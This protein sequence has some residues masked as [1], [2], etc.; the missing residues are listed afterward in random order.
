M[1]AMKTPNLFRAGVLLALL[2]LLALC[3]PHVFPSSQTKKYVILAW[4]DLGM[5]CYSPD[6]EDMAILPPY[7]N[8]FAQVIEAGDPPKIITEGIVVEYSF[9]ENTYSAGKP[10]M[11]DKTNFWDHVKKLFNAKP[12]VN[13]GLAGKRLSGIMD[14]AGDH[15]VA[16]GI[17]LTEYRDADADARQPRQDWNRYPYQLAL[18]VVK[19]KTS[20]AEL[21]RATAVAPVSS[22]LNCAKCHS[23]DGIASKE[24]KIRVTGK[25]ATNILTLHDKFNRKKY[26]VALMDSRPVLCAGCHAS[27][28]LGAK[29][30]RGIP[31]F[32]HAIHE[33]HSKVKEITPDTAG[34]YS[35]HPGSRTQC[36]R[37]VM[38]ARYNLNCLTCHGSMEKVAD[39][40][41]PWLIEPRCDS[42]ACHGN[43]YRQDKPLYK[44]SKAH[45][46]VY[47]AGCHDSPHAIAPSSHEND[48]IK[49]VQLQEHEGTLRE[50]AACHTRMPDTAFK[51]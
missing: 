10:G 27:N 45:A 38:S 14:P 18:V 11:P 41:K 34:C 30:K 5:H 44:Q 15:F 16:E 37:D 22:E 48:R 28:A 32:S 4:N 7:N 51:H 3:S 2:A 40:R 29:G 21:G 47:C 17:P 8:L 6:Y 49:F 39:N 36:L 46:G 33:H 25:V 26:A 19:E 31:N 24:G 42:R 12:A 13:T 23:D 50:C 35:C 43:G 20:G 1:I 9:T